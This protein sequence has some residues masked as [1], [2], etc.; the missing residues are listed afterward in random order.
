MIDPRPSRLKQFPTG[1]NRTTTQ[2]CLT[3]LLC[4]GAHNRAAGDAIARMKADRLRATEEA[5]A[6]LAPQRQPVEI[7]SGYDDVRAV[8]H[9]H[10]HWSHDSRGQID[11]ILPA[12]KKCGIRVIMFTEHPAPHYDYFRD[13]HQGMKDGVLCIP[14]AETGGFLAFPKRSVQGETTNGPQEFSDLVTGTGGLTFTSHV[15]ERR[16]WDIASMTGTEIYNIHADL[17][18]EKPLMARI[19]NPLGLLALVSSIEKHPQVLF[20]AIQDYPADYLKYWDD[21]C[22]KRRLTAVAANDAH[23]NQHIRAL[24][25]EE[26]KLQVLD[27][28]G[29]EAALLD[30]EKLGLLKG[31]MEN[32]KPGDAVLDVDLDPY[33]RS[34]RHVSTHLLMREVTVDEVW[35][36]LRAGRTYVAFD[37]MCDPTGFVFQV[38]AD[39]TAGE[40]GN[41][42]VGT[43][44]A[45]RPGLTARVA[46]PL[47]GKIRLMRHGAEVAVGQGRDADFNLAEPGVYRA[48]VWLDLAGEERPWILSGPIYVR[49]T[50]PASER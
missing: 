8:I 5:L 10:S 26:G 24:V 43:E 29:E 20:A 34:F 40:K 21:L 14:G 18:D 35:E 15:E 19:R 45:F 23:H 13:G 47:P 39:A 37:W 44:L 48:E 36:A 32:K 27:G 1:M 28:L 30:P 17:F 25:T 7:K 4:A 3:L 6:T 9:V 50:T 49:P 2:L 42:T 22:Q 33:E 46:V 11:E 31:L 16:E 41:F 12:A 38:Q